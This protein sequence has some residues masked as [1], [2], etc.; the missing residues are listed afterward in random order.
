MRS[1]ENFVSPPEE[2]QL[3]KSGRFGECTPCCNGIC[4]AACRG[5]SY[6]C[7]HCGHWEEPDGWRWNDDEEKWEEYDPYSKEE[8]WV[9]LESIP[10]GH[11]VVPGDTLLELYNMLPRYSCKSNEPDGCPVCVINAILE[12]KGLK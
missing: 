5:G 1:G 3:V 2:M 10:E 7:Q 8:G 4:I 12:Q 6:W 9:E 11:V